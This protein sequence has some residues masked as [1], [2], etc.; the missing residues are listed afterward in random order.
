MVKTFSSNLLF[1]VL[2]K[3]PSDI[4]VGLDS[5]KSDDKYLFIFQIGFTNINETI[6]KT[7]AKNSK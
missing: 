6:A 2:I 4:P 5:Q 3:Q 1:Y 7:L